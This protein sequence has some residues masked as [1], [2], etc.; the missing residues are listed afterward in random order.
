MAT[1]NVTRRE[2]HGEKP[3]HLRRRGVVPMAL[4]D[5]G[6]QTH[7]LQAPIDALKRAFQDT[8]SHGMI[9]VQV[10]GETT[11]RRAVIKSV[12]TDPIAH[13]VLAVTLQ[14]VSEGDKIR[15]E[16]PVVADGHSEDVDAVNIVLT[17]VTTTLKV[18][19]K[20]SELPEAIHVDVSN[21]HVGDHISASDI[22]LPNGVEL[23]SA[24]ES[25]LFTMSRIAEPNLEAEEAPTSLVEDDEPEAPEPA[26]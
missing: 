16:L 23:Q 20:V 13:Q 11:A 6:H 4:V 25:V 7:M 15:A 22:A 10:D 12:S 2:E 9:D 8:D 14:E 21:M 26:A 1:F 24:P 17:A 5:R 19:G 3:R 18:R